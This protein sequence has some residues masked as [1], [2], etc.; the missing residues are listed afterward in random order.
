MSNAIVKDHQHEFAVVWRALH[1]IC[2]SVPPGDLLR[3][4]AQRASDT[5]LLLMQAAGCLSSCHTGTESEPGEL[6]AT[7]A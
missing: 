4:E 5:L 7:A 1:T 2:Q 3:L 6:N